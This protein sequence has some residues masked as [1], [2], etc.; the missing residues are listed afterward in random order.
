M[1]KFI[2]AFFL[3]ISTTAFTQKHE[4]SLGYRIGLD[5]G[6]ESDE[7]SVLTT[8]FDQ[9]YTIGF[10]YRIWKK[11]KLY[12]MLGYDNSVTKYSIYD[13]IFGKP[14]KHER[15]NQIKVNRHGINFGLNKKFE[16][17]KFTI[18]IGVNASVR[19][20]T[21]RKSTSHAS[22]GLNDPAPLERF[23]RFE[24]RPYFKDLGLEYKAGVSYAFA[25]HFSVNLGFCY[26]RG[27]YLPYE[28]SAEI[29]NA[30]GVTTVSPTTKYYELNQFIYINA[31]LSYNL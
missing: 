17:Q 9:G 10:K 3:I 25:D 19:N 22:G 23:F 14:L 26:S 16:I 2:L 20:K 11:A 1:S 6:N 5:I 27:H 30:D 28:S 24:T 8:S 15:F 18:D 12:V 7:K 13:D 31:G 29:I 21:Y 4:L